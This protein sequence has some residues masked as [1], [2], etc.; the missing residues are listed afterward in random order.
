[1]AETYYA[2]SP[3]RAGGETDVVVDPLGRERRIIKSR[4]LIDV[5]EKVTADDIAEGDEDEFQ[6]FIDSGAVRPY[7]YPDVD[8]DV[9]PPVEFLRRRIREQAEVAMNE[10]EQLLM[11]AGMGAVISDQD[12]VELQPKPEAKAVQQAADKTATAKK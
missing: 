1:M 5:G 6:A 8:N 11:A 3:I 7:P 12:L 10:E 4:N 2:W 9:E